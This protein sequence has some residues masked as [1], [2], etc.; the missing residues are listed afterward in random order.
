LEQNGAINPGDPVYIAI[1][2]AVARHLLADTSLTSY[3]FNALRPL[4]SGEITQFLGCEFRLSN[5]IATNQTVDMTGT[6][7]GVVT[8]STALSAAYT[9]MYT[10]SAM[11]FGMAQDMTVRF[12]ELPERGY[13]LQCFHSL[14]L[15]AVRMDPKKIVRIGSLN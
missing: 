10:R 9:Y 12:D 1:H 13:S 5:Q 11:V 7:A 4:M 6:T 2:P 3:D 8:T 15:G 14:G